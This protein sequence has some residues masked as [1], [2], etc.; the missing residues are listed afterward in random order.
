MS[1]KVSDSPHDTARRRDVYLP[2]LECHDVEDEVQKL[3]GDGRP[4]RTVGDATAGVM[5]RRY[6][7]N[8]TKKAVIRTK[9][10]AQKR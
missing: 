10:N 5:P 4:L 1:P 3:E 7:L 9:E 6:H 2:H 8:P